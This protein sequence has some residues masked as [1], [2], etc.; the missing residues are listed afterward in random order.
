[1]ERDVI[2][3]ARKLNL[4]VAPWGVLGQVCIH[5]HTHTPAPHAHAH[6]H[7]RIHMHK[8]AT[9]MHTETCALTHSHTHVLCHAYACQRTHVHTFAINE[10]SHVSFSPLVFT[11][12]LN[13]TLCLAHN[14]HCRANTLASTRKA[15]MW[16]RHVLW[17]K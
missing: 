9:L 3:M 5:A 13:L 14:D 10:R 16:I 2:P 4:A 7:T 6:T 1:M 8:R 11:T 12:P 15:S 17:S